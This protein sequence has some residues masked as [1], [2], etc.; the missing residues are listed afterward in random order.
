MNTAEQVTWQ[1]LRAKSLDKMTTI[2]ETLRSCGYEQVDAY[3]INRF[4][5]RVR[6]VDPRLDEIPFHERG[7]FV[8]DDLLKIPEEIEENITSLFL[9]SPREL[10]ASAED[11]LRVYS[12]NREFTEPTLSIL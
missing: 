6:I 12:M 1:D 7:S 3:P 2:E 4:A 8:A 11:E 5:F 9:F 10:A